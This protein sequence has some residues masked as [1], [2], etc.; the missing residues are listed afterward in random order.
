[1]SAKT[2]V[3]TDES[4]IRDLISDWV[5][6]LRAKDIDGLMAHYAPDVLLFDL[7]PPLQYDGAEAYRKLWEKCF[8]F[9]DETTASYEVRDLKITISGDLAFSHGFHQMSTNSGHEM[10]MRLTSCYRKIDGRWLV[11]HDHFSVPIDMEGNKPLMNL[12]P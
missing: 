3:S 7:M 4:Q 6:A 2:S 10:C 5:T 11:V 8:S 12:Q 9:C 1:M